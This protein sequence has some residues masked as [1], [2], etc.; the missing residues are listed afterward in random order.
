LNIPG[1]P[2]HIDRFDGNP[3][4]KMGEAGIAMGLSTP[5]R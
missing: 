3:L 5:N 4:A 2:R 1:T